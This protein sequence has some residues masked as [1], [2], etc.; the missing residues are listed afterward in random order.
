MNIVHFSATLLAGAPGRLV[1]LLNR[2]DGVHARLVHLETHECFPPDLHF[3]ESRE[4]VLELVERADILHLHNYFDESSQD[5]APVDF[6]TLRKSGKRILRQYHTHPG[7]IAEKMGI[8][9]ETLLNDD[10]PSLVIAQFQERYYP[11]ARVVPNPLPINDPLYR[12]ASGSEEILHE[13]VFTPTRDSDAWED[14]WNTKGL[15]ET[16]AMLRLVRK[17]TK[18]RF[19]ILARV[20][21]EEVLRRKRQ[22]RI[23][24]DELVTGSYHLSG[25]EGLALGRPVLAYLDERT[26]A[27]LRTVTG[28]DRSPFVN[29]RLENAREVLNELLKDRE[30]AEEIGRAS[31]EWMER[32]WKEETVVRRYLDAYHDLLDNPEKIQRQ[33]ELA[34]EGKAAFFQAI[35]LPDRLHDSR[36]NLYPDGW[37][38]KRAEIGL[39]LSVLVCRFRTW[40]LA[41]VLNPTVYGWLL[42]RL[43]DRLYLP[44]REFYRRRIKKLLLRYRSKP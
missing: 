44:V 12:P 22:S 27:V 8:S 13:I 35:T 38:I 26:R 32:Y 10:L 40:M 37:R 43:P 5:F 41:T 25:L 34:I 36:K 14:R 18:A 39:R 30:T 4:E 31:R 19:A 21:L 1:D 17:D 9:V 2:Q 20:P 16:K 29:T 7:F 24:I 11:K 23:V 3:P 6:R 33:P 15:L 42:R 28:S